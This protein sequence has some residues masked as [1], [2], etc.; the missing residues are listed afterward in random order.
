MKERRSSELR[1]DE[2]LVCIFKA[3]FLAFLLDKGFYDPDA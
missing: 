3:G 2:R 1:A